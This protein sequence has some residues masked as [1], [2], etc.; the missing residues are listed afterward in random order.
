MSKMTLWIVAGVVLFI[1]VLNSFF[2]VR[3]TEQ[4]MVVALGRV[5]RLVTE[6]G[7]HMKVPF[8][9]QLVVFDKRILQM[10]ST[11][12]EVQT[13]DKKRVV[14]DSFTRWQI[15]D[16][17]Q[18]YKSLRSTNNA[19]QKLAF[20]V[21][22]NIR[23]VVASVELHDLVS[24]ERAKVMRQILES[25][26]EEAEPLGIRIVDVRIKRADLPTENSEAVFRRMRAERQKE[27]AEIRASGEEKAQKI[28]ADAEKQRTILLAEAER[29]SAK[30]RGEGDAQAIRI[31]GAA[32]GQDPGFYK[33]TRSLEAY[34]DSLKGSTFVL[35][36]GTTFLDTMVGR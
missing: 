34:R 26:R 13:L 24:G 14:V 19:L 20:I 36:P 5:E 18:F 17:G 33:L 23:N 6:P 7:L 3:E 1:T 28:R 8:Y 10:H 21:D 15:V 30:L 31:G 12:N 29:D 2:T 32:F 35:D 4:V 25:T 27:A 11:P 16:A 9:H 22:S